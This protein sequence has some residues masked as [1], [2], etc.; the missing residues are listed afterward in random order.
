MIARNSNRAAGIIHQRTDGL[1]VPAKRAMVETNHTSAPNSSARL[2][3]NITQPLT[4]VVSR[5][6]L[7]DFTTF[8]FIGRF[9]SSYRSDIT[10]I[11]Q[12]KLFFGLNGRRRK[13]FRRQLAHHDSTAARDRPG[14]KCRNRVQALAQKMT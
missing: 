4:A 6:E 3:S 8:V 1:S 2:T 13:D 5:S 9:L 11:F 12:V 7:T 10:L 14:R